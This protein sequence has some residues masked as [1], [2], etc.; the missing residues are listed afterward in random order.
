MVQPV[1]HAVV[2]PAQKLAVHRAARRQVRWQRR[3]LAAGTENIQDPV[4]DLAH[5]DRALVAA[6]L[7]PAE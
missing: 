3:P 5:I 6:A 4:D 2:L 1:E 7:A